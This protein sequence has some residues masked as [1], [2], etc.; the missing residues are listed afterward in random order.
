M[1][2]GKGSEAVV[3]DLVKRFGMNNFQYVFFLYDNDFS[4][5]SGYR[6]FEKSIRIAV[7]R[8]MK[9]WYFKRF[10]H[11]D[12]VEVYEYIFLADSDADYSQIHPKTIMSTLREFNIQVAQPSH[13]NQSH[14]DWTHPGQ[15]PSFHR[16][17]MK[18]IEESPLRALFHRTLPTEQQDPGYNVEQEKKLLQETLKSESL[19]DVDAKVGR[20][21]DFV[22]CGPLTI[23]SREAWNCF[24]KY[25]QNDGATGWGYDFYFETLCAP[26]QAA[27]LD[28][29][30]LYH[31]HTHSASSN[32]VYKRR[33][34]N[35]W[36]TVMRR[37]GNTH[38]ARMMF[39]GPITL[40][41]STVWKKIHNE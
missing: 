8:Q 29:Q 32:K 26:R 41:N 22:E 37:L 16:E 36:Q 1:G 39:Y 2:I 3:D 25:I 18:N 20:W 7:T 34:K 15:A 28:N 24:W 17:T 13:C 27:L 21:T 38:K 30:C 35:E 6:W 40:S 4:I 14:S 10:L 12:V 5:W 9:W 19:R 31:L 11:P 33:K 23:F